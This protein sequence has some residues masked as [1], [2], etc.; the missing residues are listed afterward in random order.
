MAK[1]K[2]VP[3]IT[4]K[5]PRTP[6]GGISRKQY[7]ELADYAEA[8]RQEALKLQ[9]E[10]RKKAR[11]ENQDHLWAAAAEHAKEV[12][13][14]TAR[15]V[16]LQKQIADKRKLHPMNDPHATKD[17]RRAVHDVEEQ[18][19]GVPDDHEEHVARLKLKVLRSQRAGGP[20]ERGK[21]V[22]GGK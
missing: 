22:G 19:Y 4:P 21:P 15:A 11:K 3:T 12:N 17:E 1:K 8:A 7:Q 18:T 2:A 10:E 16:K 5:A 6:V 9:A 20:N 14:L 13:A